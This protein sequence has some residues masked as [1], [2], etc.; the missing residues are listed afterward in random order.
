MPEKAEGGPVQ[1]PKA[2]TKLLLGLK[3]SSHQDCVE[4]VVT[5]DGVKP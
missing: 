3:L 1:S 2:R 4:L 5:V